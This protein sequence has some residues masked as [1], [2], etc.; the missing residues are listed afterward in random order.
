MT[1]GMIGLTISF[2]VIGLILGIYNLYVRKNES[3]VRYLVSIVY[4]KD[5]NIPQATIQELLSKML[6]RGLVVLLITFIAG[7]FYLHYGGNAV[8]A[9]V[10]LIVPV[11]INAVIFRGKMNRLDQQYKK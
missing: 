8:V 4:P 3:N 2:V 7:M 11:L 10:V 1:G 5:H 9:H 6:N